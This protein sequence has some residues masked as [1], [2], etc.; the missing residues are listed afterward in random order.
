MAGTHSSRGRPSKLTESQWARIGESLMQGATTREL[1]KKFKISPSAI[2][3]RFSK[4]TQNTK[5]IAKQ[6]YEAEVAVQTQPYVDQLVI[7]NMVNQMISISN[8]LASTAQHNS[9]TSSR[10]A[11][12]ANKEVEKIDAE[13]PFENME[14]FRNV[15][16][17]TELSNRA[18]QTGL[19]LL[20]ANK[21]AMREAEKEYKKAVITYSDH[22]L[23]DV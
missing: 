21:D 22:E 19:A 17:V 1:G 12:I 9:R 13:N 2:T 4:R 15:A 8:D 6:L 14:T 5:A 11:Y 18:A 10:L 20:S 3:N 16:A 23:D 7:R